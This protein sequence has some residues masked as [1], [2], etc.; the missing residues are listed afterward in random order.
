MA[1]KGSGIKS[2]ELHHRLGPIRPVFG[3]MLRVV[4]QTEVN[5]PNMTMRLDI[6]KPCAQSHTGQVDLTVDGSPSGQTTT[7]RTAGR[8]GGR[9]RA[10]AAAAGPVQVSVG[11]GRRSP[12]TR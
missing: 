7:G 2:L 10:D 1:C 11:L 4:Q 12:D 9:D 3:P 6:R 5:Q 8:G